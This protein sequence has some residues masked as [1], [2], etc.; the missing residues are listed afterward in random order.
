MALE[1]SQSNEVDLDRTDKLPVLGGVPLHHDVADDAARL[2][3][4]APAPGSPV[5]AS[6]T[7][8]SDFARPPGVDLPSLAES[9]RS[10]EERIAR[11]GAEYEALRR[12]YEKARDAEQAEVARASALAAAM[13]SA[14]S[15]LA[16]E[17][18]RSREMER[19]QA[20]ANAAAE[21]SRARVEQALRESERYQSESRTLRDSL[22][23]RDAA[24]AQALHSLGERDAQ[25][26]ALQREHA[27]TVP[28]LEARSQAAAQLEAELQ[29]ARSRAEA[30]AL[31]L[32]NTQ[33]ST[34][35]LTARLARGES[36]MNAV[37][38][39]LGTVKRQAGFYLESLRTREWRRGFDRN[40]FLEW[41]AKMDAAHAGHGA[42][43]AECD[44]LKQTAAALSGR[45]VEQDDT[46]AKLQ[47]AASDDAAALEKKARELQENQRARI[48]LAARIDAMEADRKR[49]HGELAAREQGLAEARTVG[50]GAVQRLNELLAAAEKRDAERGAQIA[51]L[52]AEAETH[53]QEMTV[54]MAHL[55]EARRP[56]QSI[57]SDVKRLSDEL[58]LKTAA[59][60]QLNEDNRGLRSA[61]ERTRGALEEREFLIRRLERSESNNANVLGRIQTSI[62]RL[63]AAPVSSASPS[64]AEYTAE[65]IRIDGDHNTTYPV[66][67]RTRIGRALG[68][69]LQ[70]DSSSVSR[71]HAL[72]LQG[73]R[74][75]IIEDLNSTNGVV[76]NDRKVSRQILRDGDLVTIGEIQFRCVLKPTPR[77]AD[78]PSGPP[79]GE[80]PAA[81]DS[82]V[83]PVDADASGADPAG[84][85]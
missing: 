69:E 20:E 75:L 7:A 10:V 37:R 16:V 2:D 21:A 5:V 36:E 24:I 66:V 25:L 9:V 85:P 60:E 79:A 73:A 80:V 62:E 78:A 64:A 11:Q 26:H 6:Q 39:E 77:A 28:A 83:R 33:E 43:Q 46:I 72:L 44:R 1:K 19:A 8:Q 35:A 27:Q 81:A 54:L 63:G 59:L 55:N 23:A 42:L 30:V 38:Q 74:E 18:H 45:L 65:L 40:Q 68:C 34:A 70:I 31:E 76:V 50:A 84:A 17:Q 12:L 47:S 29:T 41:D 57:Q 67:R 13:A 4:T 56:V 71:H 15:A 14:Q 22:A 51:Q 3:H 82:G 61:L 58:A 32:K 48:E 52:Q 49:M 53:E